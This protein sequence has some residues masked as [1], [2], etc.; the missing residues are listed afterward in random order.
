M[1]SHLQPDR[2]G[3]TST[4]GPPLQPDPTGITSTLGPTLHLLQ[5]A[6][7]YSRTVPGSPLQ[8]ENPYIRYNETTPSAE[9][10]RDHCSNGITP[11]SATM[12][13]PLRADRTWIASTMGPPLQPLQW[14]HPY[15]RTVP[16]SP[17]QWD[18]PY[19]RNNLTTPTAGPF[20]DHLY[21]GTT[22]KGLPYRDDR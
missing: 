22:C 17:L 5:W 13:P 11:K 8:W 1:G 10:Y 7:P 19:T 2:T 6:H 16:G 20:R 12:G 4:M 18:H 9:P 21:T 15:S 3:I 14:H